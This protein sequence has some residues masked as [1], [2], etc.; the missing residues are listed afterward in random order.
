[1]VCYYLNFLLNIHELITPTYHNYSASPSKYLTS[2]VCQMI[3]I[4][5]KKEQRLAINVFDG[6]NIQ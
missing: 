4:N 6:C 3:T 1:M 2:W 5:I